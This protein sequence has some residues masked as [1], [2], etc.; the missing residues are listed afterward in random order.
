MISN[1]IS[2]KDLKECAEL[3]VTVFSGE[4]WNESI[5]Q[6]MAM[7]RLLF[8]LSMPN[9]ISQKY[10]LEDNIIGFWIGY[11]EP[12]ADFTTL[13]IK[14]VL[15]HPNMQG[16]GI[17]KKLMGSAEKYGFEKKCNKITLYARQDTI[18]YSLY[19]KMGYTL[20]NEL[21]RMGKKI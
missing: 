6:T 2:N 19:K 5:N 16:K 18:A 15:V 14:E 7:Q 20:S 17:G 11:I 10:I 3:Y 13:F 12:L 8:L 4:P 21:V 1:E 9:V